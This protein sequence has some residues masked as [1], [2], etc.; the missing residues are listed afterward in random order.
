V[1]WHPPLRSD[2][3][4]SGSPLSISSYGRLF[5]NTL[6]VERTRAQRRGCRFD[7]LPT[8]LGSVT[9]ASSRTPTRVLTRQAR[10]SKIE[11]EVRSIL[12]GAVVRDQP[13]W[14]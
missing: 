5:V 11:T 14:R 1:G 13:I 8:P 6:V 3:G 12:D 10:R 9:R 7:V 4:C 2:G